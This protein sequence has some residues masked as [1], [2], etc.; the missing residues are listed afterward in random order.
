M[1][2]GTVFC[3]LSLFLQIFLSVS[4]RE[5]RII[6]FDHNK[7]ESGFEDCIIDTNI[8]N[9]PL[10]TSQTFHLN[11][12]RKQLYY[13]TRTP[14]IHFWFSW[15]INASVYLKGGDLKIELELG[16]VGNGIC[17]RTGINPHSYCL[18]WP[19]LEKARNFWNNISEHFWSSRY[20]WIFILLLKYEFLYKIKT[21]IESWCDLE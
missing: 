13:Q 5:S 18:I 17:H 2:E 1:G 21:N 6:L 4:K 20:G 19:L 11:T 14:L 12:V 16:I 9:F 10:Q 8:Q 3:L 15:E 7:F